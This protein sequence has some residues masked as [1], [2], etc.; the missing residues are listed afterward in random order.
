MNTHRS[1]SSHAPQA[2]RVLL[3]GGLLANGAA[4]LAAP[5]TWYRSVP[6]VEFTG[7]F[8]PHFVRD[9]G[10][11]YA[12]A[13]LGLAWRAWRGPIAAPAAQLGALFLLLH[14][15]IH[16]GETLAGICGWRTLLADVPGVIVPAALA[17]GLAGGR[18]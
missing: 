17:L 5:A 8:N 13:A 6:G 12:T 1:L 18:R 4:M 14:A 11:A 10:A 9:I 2:L 15:A 3:A 16:V 7:P